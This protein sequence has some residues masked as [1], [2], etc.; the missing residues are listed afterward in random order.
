MKRLIEAIFSIFFSLIMGAIGL[1][2][3]ALYAPGFLESLQIN[4]SFL[5]DDILIIF[6][7]LGTQSNVNVWIR[8]LL[9]DE[10]L[11]FMGFVIASRI[12][13]TLFFVLIDSLTDMAFPKRAEEG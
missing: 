10:Q 12:I 3:C 6:T 4:A 2:L 9:Q 5:K 7:S 11:V 1:A 13:I 8:F